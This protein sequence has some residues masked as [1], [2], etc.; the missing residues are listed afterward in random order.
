MG[1][2]GSVTICFRDGK[3]AGGREN[4]RQEGLSLRL[5]ENYYINRR[6]LFVLLCHRQEGKQ[7]AADKEK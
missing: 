1:Y 2:V 3:C 6:Q 7:E 5:T 4:P